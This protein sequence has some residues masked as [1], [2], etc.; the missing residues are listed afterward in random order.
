MKKIILF[1]AFAVSYITS[2]AQVSFGAQMGANLS[3]GKAGTTFTD[4]F[5]SY[6]TITNDPKVGPTVG[7]IAEIPLGKKFAFRPELNFIQKGSTIGDSE[8]FFGIQPKKKIT[9]NYI[10]LP[11]NVIYKLNVGSGNFFLGL[12]TALAF[13]ISGKVKISH[14]TNQFLNITSNVKFDG[15]KND[16]IMLGF[17]NNDSHLKRF[18]VGV[19]ALAGYKLQ[20]GLFFKLGYNYG[21]LNIDPNKDNERSLDQ[22]TYK[23]RG[24]NICIGYM[25]GGSKNDD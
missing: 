18:D 23:N 17:G 1:S 7:L 19:N 9:L 13:G 15:K 24:F 14:P 3:L 4:Q 12:G 10:E 6:S 2:M 20:N 21:I 25:I 8:T 5:S 11:L 16:D 22:T